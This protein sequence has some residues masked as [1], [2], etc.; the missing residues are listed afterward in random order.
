MRQKRQTRQN[1]SQFIRHLLSFLF[2]IKKTRFLGKNVHVRRERRINSSANIPWSKKER[3]KGAVLNRPLRPFSCLKKISTLPFCE[4]RK[5]QPF[6]FSDEDDD[7][8]EE[9]I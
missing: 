6:R 2:G 7:Y 5:I 8:E 4:F 1:L 3:N 9:M